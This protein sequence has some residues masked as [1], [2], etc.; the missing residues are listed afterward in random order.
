MSDKESH[1]WQFFH[2]RRK[3]LHATMIMLADLLSTDGISEAKLSHA[4]ELGEYFEIKA[5]VIRDSRKNGKLN[6]FSLYQ[7]LFGGSRKDY[8]KYVLESEHMREL[9]QKVKQNKCFS[10]SLFSRIESVLERYYH[11]PRP[12]L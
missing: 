7:V 9:E 12:L 3:R 2:L 8:Q 6:S 1:F 11:T 4:L 10:V 5:T